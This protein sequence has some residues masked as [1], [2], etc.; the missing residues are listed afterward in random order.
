MY[1]KSNGPNKIAIG[2]LFKLKYFVMS[3]NFNIFTSVAVRALDFHDPFHNMHKKHFHQGCTN[4]RPI[5]ID[6]KT[7]VLHC[8]IN[9]FLSSSFGNDLFLTFHVCNL[10]NM[11]TIKKKTQRIVDNVET[12]INSEKDLLHQIDQ[13][14]SY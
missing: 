7:I 11:F 10:I 8:E 3:N 4:K 9:M 14:I 2:I 12:S 1:T 6:D 13:S 5:R